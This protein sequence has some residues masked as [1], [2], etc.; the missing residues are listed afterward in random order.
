MKYEVNI[1]N[2]NFRPADIAIT[3]RLTNSTLW[4][5]VFLEKLAVVQ[6]IS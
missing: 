2:P 6:I 1:Q 4:S 5:N 3:F